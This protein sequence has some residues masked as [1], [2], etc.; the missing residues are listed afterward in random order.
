V[1]RLNQQIN[2]YMR[3]IQILLCVLAAGSA[4]A[5][6]VTNYPLSGTNFSDLLFWAASIGD[7]T[8]YNVPGSYLASAAA[9]NDLSNT[10]SGL[11]SVAGAGFATNGPD[12]YP[13]LTTNSSLAGAKVTGAVASATV[14]AYVSGTLSN[15]ISGTAAVATAYSGTIPIGSV[16]TPGQIATNGNAN[17]FTN[18]NDFT[19]IGTN[20]VTKL[21]VGGAAETSDSVNVTGSARVST[22]LYVGGNVTINVTTDQITGL[23]AV[24]MNGGPSIRQKASDGTTAIIA[25]GSTDTTPTGNLACSNANF[26]GTITATNGVWLP[27]NQAVLAPQAWGGFLWNSNNAL[28]WVTTTH[29]NYIAGP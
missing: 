19:V 10:V 9:V 21:R 22:G 20:R 6:N 23:A 18:N 1:N 26:G 25:S 29:T 27:T 12:G 13:L 16:T 3:R 2:N 28:Y 14:A 8:N 5:I 11:G 4:Q 15:S 17:L 24:R 7:H